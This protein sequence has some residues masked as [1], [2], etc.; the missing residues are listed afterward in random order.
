MKGAR[1]PSLTRRA[2]QLSFPVWNN[3]LH[4]RDP[5][6]WFKPTAIVTAQNEEDSNRPYA[7]QGIDL[8]AVA[9]SI[10]SEQAGHT[11]PEITWIGDEVKK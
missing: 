10:H 3:I 4:F 8:N 1:A 2:G 6:E 9:N 7:S 11:T 5:V